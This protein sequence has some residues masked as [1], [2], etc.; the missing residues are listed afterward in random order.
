MPNIPFDC[1]VSH[2]ALLIKQSG[3]LHIRDSSVRPLEFFVHDRVVKFLVRYVR[4]VSAYLRR[5]HLVT[6]EN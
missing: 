1:V 4:S 3:M 6:Y 5:R 2:M